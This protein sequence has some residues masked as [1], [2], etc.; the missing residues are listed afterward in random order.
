MP[1][2]WNSWNQRA[3]ILSIPW[4]M[5]RHASCVP[6][7]IRAIPPHGVQQ[8]LTINAI[9][10]IPSPAVV[11]SSR[12]HPRSFSRDRELHACRP[13]RQRTEWEHTKKSQE[14]VFW[15]IHD[16]GVWVFWCGSVATRT[17]W[18]IENLTASGPATTF[19][20]LRISYACLTFQI[21]S[22]WCLVE[23]VPFVVAPTMKAN[24]PS[25]IAP[26]TIQI[27][28]DSWYIWS[29]NVVWSPVKWMLLWDMWKHLVAGNVLLATLAQS[30][31][32]VL[33]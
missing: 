4:A 21:V 11:E 12:A 9:P 3:R 33:P 29:P 31:G 20:A 23:T 1:P 2:F 25:H 15:I 10:P 7:T 6:A 17:S 16:E 14:E 24:P 13:T 18:L 5:W 8:I 19:Q 32:T 22:G 26:L 30:A 27:P 28:T